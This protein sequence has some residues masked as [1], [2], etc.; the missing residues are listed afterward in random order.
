MFVDDQIGWGDKLQEEED[1]LAP[2]V[3]WVVEMSQNSPNKD[4]PMEQS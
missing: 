3:V 1:T 2:L 4:S